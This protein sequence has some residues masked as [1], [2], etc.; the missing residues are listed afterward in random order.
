[1]FIDLFKDEL[2]CL[3]IRDRVFRF[4]LAKYN[5]RVQNIDVLKYGTFIIPEDCV[6]QGVI[7]ENETTLQAITNFILK[8]KIKTKN[9]YMNISSPPIVLRIV[10]LPHMQEK[11]LSIFLQEEISQFIPVDSNSSIIDYKVLDRFEEDGKKQ[12]NVMLIAAPKQMIRR[13]V[14]LLKKTGLNP[15]VVDLYP[16]C[17]ARVFSKI[18][19]K[20]IAVLDVNS[21]A[22]DFIIL[23]NNNLFMHSNIYLESSP[24]F[25][26][27]IDRK[28]ENIVYEDKNFERA[29]GEITNYVKTYLN[30]FSSRHFGASVDRLYIIGEL[31]L[32]KDIDAYIG[33]FLQIEV[34][35]GLSDIVKVELSKGLKNTGDTQESTK[36]ALYACGLGLAMRGD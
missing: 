3:D 20:N 36:I 10:K 26:S 31:A 14:D 9:V 28:A 35:S 2:L 33:S 22:L 13:Y 11:D 15:A 30:F 12:M 16:N 25:L 23:K 19:N 18:Q 24:D 32:I 34:K 4:I 8:E 1:M 21:N 6:D 27:L 29:L 5:K 17:I 7:C